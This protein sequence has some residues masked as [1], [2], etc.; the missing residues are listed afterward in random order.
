MG[1]LDIVI[2]IVLALGM[3]KGWSA[4]FVRQAT[5]LAG[6]VLAV[7]LAATFMDG[8]GMVVETGLGITQGLGSFVAFATIFLGVMIAS[9]LVA[10]SADAAIKTLHLGG[11]NR[12]A[13]GAVGAIKAG[14]VMS[15]VFL[16]I[17]YVQLPGPKAIEESNLYNPVSRIVPEAWRILSGGAPRLE[18]IRREFERKVEERAA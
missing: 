14:I 17:S 6:L 12:A 1:L 5:R 8:L 10:R 9:S 11:L 7:V 15:L 16:A 13:G 3:A 18:E 2:L 4:G